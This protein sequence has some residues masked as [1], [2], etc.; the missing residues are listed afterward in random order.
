[1]AGRRPVAAARQDELLQA[2]QIGIECVQ[3]G[4]E[5]I[6]ELLRDRT[7][8]GDAQLTAE[9]EQVMLHLGQ[10]TANRLGHCIAGEHDADGTVRFIHGAIS[11]H[12]RTVFGNTAAVA[13]AGRAVVAGSGV[14]FA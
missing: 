6:D 8:T 3:I 5:T 14:D 2:R 9:F 7:V 12:A 1:M 13:K 4:L 11:F 10:Q